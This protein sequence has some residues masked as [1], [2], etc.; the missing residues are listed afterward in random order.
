M[1]TIVNEKYIS[2][3][4]N[5]YHILGR[6]P[7][8][9]STLLK[10]KICCNLHA[11][12]FFEH[13]V[14]YLQDQSING[15]IINGCKIH[16]QKIELKE[17]DHIQFSP[18][19]KTLWTIAD[20]TPP[21]SYLK[22]V[23]NNAILPLKKAIAINCKKG[24]FFL[25]QN[26]NNKWE[27]DNR[28]T[29]RPLLNSETINYNGHKWRFVM[30]EPI[31][32][33]VKIDDVNTKSSIE[34]K[35]SENLEHVDI[36]LKSENNSSLL[37][38]KSQNFILY[39]LAKKFTQDLDRGTE[40]NDIGWI[41]CEYLLQILNKELSTDYDCYYLNLQI[42]RI[43]HQFNKLNADF[44]TKKIIERRKGEIRINNIEISIKGPNYPIFS[45][46]KCAV[47]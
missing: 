2:I 35:L 10:S 33:T 47:I 26:K 32:A 17:G 36:I 19:D 42:Y 44:N 16:K 8:I 22:R 34:F 3:F 9:S 25:T 12:L 45:K 28:I 37:P 40:N 41:D 31:D 14:W 29:Q 39:L 21:C 38:L 24:D 23:D 15:T 4:L 13:D 1:A 18:T 11:V 46:Q 7:L 20:L 43:R 5:R 6:D 27:L 30:N